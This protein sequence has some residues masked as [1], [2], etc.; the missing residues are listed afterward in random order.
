[1]QRA[2]FVFLGGS[3][4]FE[5]VKLF[6][7][8]FLTNVD[9]CNFI[10]LSCDDVGTCELLECDRGD[11]LNISVADGLGIMVGDGVLDG[12]V[13]RV[14][15]GV[16]CWLWDGGEDGHVWVVEQ[17]SVAARV[18]VVASNR[19]RARSVAARVPPPAAAAM[20]PAVAPAPAPAP[21]RP[22]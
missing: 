8:L 19:V 16:G 11:C 18:A 6:D 17:G 9:T 5:T 3:V 13:C 4:P 15:G 1:L 10:V 12:F 22:W 7:K 20:I 21:V 2:K 14:Q